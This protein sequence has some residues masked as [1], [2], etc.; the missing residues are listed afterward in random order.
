MR[1]WGPGPG[2]YQVPNTFGA[3]PRRRCVLPKKKT[4]V[5]PR[6]PTPGPGDYTPREAS[7]KTPCAFS[8]PKPRLFQRREKSR[9]DDQLLA[10]V[11]R[12]GSPG[13]GT[14]ELA[15]VLATAGGSRGAYF[16][17][18]NKLESRE[19]IRGNDIPGPG[20]YYPEKVKMEPSKVLRGADMGER[21]A[22]YAKAPPAAC[23][24][25]S[26]GPAY[27]DVDV[28]ITYRDCRA[29]TSGTRAGV[30]LPKS[31]AFGFEQE[32][33]FAQK[34][35]G[36]FVVPGPGTYVKLQDSALGSSGRMATMTPRRWH[37]SHLNPR[38]SPVRL[39]AQGIS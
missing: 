2:A 19:E 34:A 29:R 1:S 23:Q 3:D 33:R 8:F 30:D 27:Y 32:P 17:H 39:K 24:P 16:A 10:D 37:N 26:P 38:E 28:D 7:R 4:R 12:V 21:S 6:Q 5:P 18:A 22:V 14:Y 31:P 36:S 9:L 20:E 15:N 25:E 11:V 13:P 35:S